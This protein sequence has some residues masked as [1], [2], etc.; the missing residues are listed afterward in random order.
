MHEVMPAIAQAMLA[1]VE[2]HP[3]DPVA[4]LADALISKADEQDAA[5]VDPYSAGIY[6]ERRNKVDAKAYREANRAA[7][8]NARAEKQL[9]A[10]AKADA[11]LYELL[12]GS[13]A[14]HENL[15]KRG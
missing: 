8:I 9:A 15:L 1:M 12:V 10:K 7:A 6:E 4:F 5:H 11:G 3:D 14:K 13:V 2:A